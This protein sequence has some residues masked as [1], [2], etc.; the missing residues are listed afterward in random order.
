LDKAKGDE[1]EE[2]AAKPKRK[3][4]AKDEAESNATPEE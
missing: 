4:A 1:G 3:R 2:P